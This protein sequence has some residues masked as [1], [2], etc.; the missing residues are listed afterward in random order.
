MGV[1][2]NAGRILSSVMPLESKAWCLDLASGEEMYTVSLYLT[3]PVCPIT[4]A[5][6]TVILCGNI[7]LQTLGSEINYQC[8]DTLPVKMV[9]SSYGLT[10]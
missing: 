8:L 5:F 1:E 7:T 2:E 6:A 9:V 10:F 3:L 4:C